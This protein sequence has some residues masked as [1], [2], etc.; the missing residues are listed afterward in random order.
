MDFVAGQLQDETRFRSLTIVYVYT[1]GA[2]EITVGQS[3]KGD[4]EVRTLNR[5]KL[6]RG[7]RRCCSV[8][9]ALSS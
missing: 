4:D 2:V 1:R 5:V 6:E 3:L 8:T 7:V 9:M